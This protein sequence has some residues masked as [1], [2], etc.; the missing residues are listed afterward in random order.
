MIKLR[1]IFY[2]AGAFL[3]V[4]IKFAIDVIGKNAALEVGGL[5]VF[6]EVTVIG[7]FVFL[8]L[9]ADATF[10]RRDQN[11]VR[12]LGVLLIMMVAML[13]VG[14]VLNAIP[15]AGF[16]AKNLALIP[17]DYPTIFVASLEGLTYGIF[18][19]LVLQSLRDL[20]LYQRKRGTFR[21]FLILIGLILA[22]SASAVVQ[23][24]LDT[25]ILTGILT[26]LAVLFAIVNSF[27]L[28]WIVYL[29][30]R[31]KYYT[32][33]FTFL[34]LGGFTIINTILLHTSSS[35]RSILYYSFP[36]KIF[37]D[38]VITFGNIF[39]GLAFISTLF[40][41][42]TAEAFDRKRSEVA[43]LHNLGRLITQVFDFNELMDTVTSM[44]LE[45][46]EASSSW[47]E[48]IH[49][50]EEAIAE[51]ATAQML[52]QSAPQ[53]PSVVPSAVQREGVRYLVQIAGMKNISEPEIEQI[54]AAGDLNIREAVMVDLKP[55]VVDDFSADPR[56]MHLRKSGLKHGSLVV[57]PLVS[58]G[59][60]IGIL[61]ATKEAKYGFVKDDVELISAF[62]DQA[63]I[64]IDNS[65]LIKKSIDRERL[66]REM[67]VAQEMQRKLLPQSVP[68]SRSLEI[69]AVSTPAFEVGGDYYDFVELAD[70]RIGIIVGDVSGKGV[71]AA[72]YMSVVKGIFQSL[73]KTCS[74]PREFMI[75]A[76][77]AL[78]GSIDKHSFVSLIYAILHKGTGTLTLARA[79]HCPMLHIGH[80]RVEYIR[81]NGMGVGLSIGPM[82]EGAIQERTITLNEGDVCVFYTDGIT[83]ARLGDEEFGYERLLEVAQQS[84]ADRAPDICRKI[85][86]TVKVFTENQANHDDLTLVVLK[87]YGAR[88]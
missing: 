3:L 41:L 28:P 58:H 38:L 30:R 48:V 15:V 84:R 17:L 88:S 76:N 16:D 68:K 64:A 20:S 13:A 10:R 62:A 72:F 8:F 65:R 56:F 9:T 52:L 55:L 7:T 25:S 86:D 73:G 23:K 35:S 82:F 4:L 32:L 85:L 44:T 37:V 74:S 36:M 1:R 57:V 19:L 11:P 33:I 66:F 87:W 75:K 18:A 78:S 29:S 67:L 14:I 12:R 45:V 49:S 24:P 80:D 40:H 27:R 46:C 69:D 43:S 54:V 39:F 60:M 79:G 50:G 51:R 31:E 6:R 2:L 53:Q 81:P 47:L 34:L 59:A 63:T 77:E 71:P 83:E 26:A 61:Y 42:P 22:A 5:S 70:D 21:N